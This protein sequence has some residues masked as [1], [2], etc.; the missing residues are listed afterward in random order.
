MPGTRLEDSPAN[1]VFSKDNKVYVFY[2][3]ADTGT[4]CWKCFN[5]KY[6]SADAEVVIEETWEKILMHGSPGVVEFQDRLLCF[7]RG[8]SD[9]EVWY[10]IFNG[11]S[12]L[13]PSSIGSQCSASPAP[14][15]F[16]GMLYCFFQSHSGSG[17]LIYRTLKLVYGAHWSDEQS[18]SSGPT[19][20]ESPSPVLWND[21]LYICFQ[22]ADRD[23]TLKYVVSNGDTWSDVHEVTAA[24]MSSSPAAII[25]DG[26]IRVFHQS[27]GETG[28][29]CWVDLQGPYGDV[30]VVGIKMSHSPAVIEFEGKIHCLHHGPGEN[31][32]LWGLCLPLDGFST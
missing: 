7:Y 2:Q 15:V 11:E 3:G 5:G 32:E 23:G 27:L 29:L 4:L 9:E 19:M 14:V 12:W 25:V 26:G 28:R 6:W 10:A 30:P 22:G 31:G 21:K 8:R 24:R 1:I 17:R 18:V 20:S 16:E 13:E